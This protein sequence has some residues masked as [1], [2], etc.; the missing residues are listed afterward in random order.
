MIA[1][2]G[3]G[4]LAAADAVDRGKGKCT[5]HFMIPDKHSL[6]IQ[7]QHVANTA[8]YKGTGTRQ[9]Y[10]SLNMSQKLDI[11]TVLSSSFLCVAGVFHHHLT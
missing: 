1:I 11:E 7:G 5:R 3:S 4:K 2:S 8:V 10:G 9:R 6:W